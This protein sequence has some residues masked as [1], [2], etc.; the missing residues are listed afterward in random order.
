MRSGLPGGSAGEESACHVED[1]GS[2]P[3]SGRSPGRG[4]P[5]TPALT[6]QCADKALRTVGSCAS[7]PSLP[8]LLVLFKFIQLLPTVGQTHSV[9]SE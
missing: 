1:L 6:D 7:P 8:W 2:S 3:G 4:R 5:P 9:L